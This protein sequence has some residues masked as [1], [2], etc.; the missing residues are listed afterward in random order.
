MRHPL[1]A[2]QLPATWPHATAQSRDHL[3]HLQKALHFPGP[4]WVSEGSGGSGGTQRRN[5]QGLLWCGLQKPWLHAGQSLYTRWQDWMEKWSSASWR[6][7]Q[8]C[9]VV[10]E[11][12]ESPAADRGAGVPVCAP[13]HYSA[14]SS[15]S[16]VDR[17]AV[18]SNEC[19]CGGCGGGAE[20]SYTPEM[21]CHLRPRRKR[22][23]P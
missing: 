8:G 12:P 1:P 2:P 9:V 11:V 5:V 18:T 20:L 23:A 15:M 19:E 6:W 3:Q 14:L 13:L 7:C 21:S 17:W 16:Q 22:K 4:A 10:Q